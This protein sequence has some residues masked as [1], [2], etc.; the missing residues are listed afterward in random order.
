MGVIFPLFRPL[1]FGACSSTEMAHA[2]HAAIIRLARSDAAQGRQGQTSSL[3]SSKGLS[4]VGGPAVA[5]PGSPEEQGALTRFLTVAQRRVVGL[6]SVLAMDVGMSQAL[7][8]ASVVIT[9]LQVAY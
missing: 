9:N 6:G 2:S 3:K 8:L 5:G 4:K 1:L 7:V